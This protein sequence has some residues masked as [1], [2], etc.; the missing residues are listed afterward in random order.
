[1]LEENRRP[2]QIGVAALVIAVVLIGGY[3][4]FRGD[5]ESKLTVAS[6]PNDLTLTLDGQQIAANGEVKVKAGTHTLTAERRGF[7][8]YTQTVTA[9]GGDPLSVRMYLYANSSEGRAWGQEHPEQLQQTEAEAGRRFDE[10]NRR[11]REKYP[12]MAVLPYLGPG[13]KATYESSKSDP[14]NPEAIS[15]VI[16]TYTPD[17]KTKALQWIQ[18]NGWD[19][20][21]LDIIYT[22]TG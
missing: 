18:G 7:Q 17:G 20:A 16:A 13:F 11:L 9:S 8:S 19:P 6:I 12:I 4:L 2:V 3:L 14:N 10:I 22:T 1:M 21:T 15:I 5:P